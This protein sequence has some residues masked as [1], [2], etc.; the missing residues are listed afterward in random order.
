MNETLAK[1]Y[2]PDQSA[3]EAVETVGE[4]NQESGNETV[5]EKQ[6]LALQYRGVE[7]EKFVAKLKSCGAPVQ[8]VLTLRKLKTHLSPKPAIP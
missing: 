3:N 4:G 8:I 6:V 2:N 7:T 1:I 5:P